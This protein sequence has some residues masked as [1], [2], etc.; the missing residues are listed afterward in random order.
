MKKMTYAEQL[1]HPN[2]QRKRLQ[3]LEAAK[4]ICT[5]CEATDKTLHV[6]HKKYVKGRMAWEYDASELEVLCEDCHEAEHFA[7]ADL[8][9]LLKAEWLD[10][11]LQGREVVLGFLAGFLSPFGEDLRIKEISERA[12]RRGMPFFDLGFAVA[13]LG[14]V[15]VASALRKKVDE[16]R[17]PAHPFVDYV[18]ESLG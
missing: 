2:W 1:K 3:M 10:K 4:W 8:E 11:D 16:G 6:H 15:D 5:C 17:L 14:P 9:Y 13:A 7:E 18:L 12:L